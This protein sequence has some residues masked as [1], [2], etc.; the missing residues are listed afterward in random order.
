MKVLVVGAGVIGLST[1]LELL[2]QGYS[3]S[4]VAESFPPHT[5]S[6]LAGALWFP[7][8]V[9]LREK[10]CQ[11]AKRTYL[12]FRSM[13]TGV[14]IRWIP[15]LKLECSQERPWWKDMF[16]CG[17][18]P[19]PPY[20][21]PLGYPR[22]FI[23]DVPMIEPGP[24]LEYLFSL[25]REQGGEVREKKYTSL[26]EALEESPVVVN[27]TGLGARE[28]AKDPSVYPISGHMVVVDAPPDYAVLDDESEVAPCYIFPRQQVALLGGT[29]E[30]ED[31]DERV[32]LDRIG[33]ILSSCARLNPQI[34]YSQVLETYVG[35]RPGRDTVR[36]EVEKRKEGVVI[37]NYGHGGAGFTLSWGVAEEVKKL[38]ETAL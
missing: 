1:A 12:R 27:C 16:P 14:G 6:N 18:S 28:F 36:L 17:V 23:A 25:F 9:G 15:L 8:Q 34:L 19:A 2:K 38:L 30:K 32:R 37:H 7:C 24:Y 33:K 31:L 35:L 5:T 4:L 22:G 20:L 3:V 26:E 10:V 29:A 21:I 13:Q 11:W